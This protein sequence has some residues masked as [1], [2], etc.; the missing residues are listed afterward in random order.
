M[1]VSKCMCLHEKMF[2]IL[3]IREMQMKATMRYHLTPVKIAIIKKSTKSKCWGE[4]DL[5][6]LLVGL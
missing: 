6:T 3:I 1:C 2:S 4:G 5:P